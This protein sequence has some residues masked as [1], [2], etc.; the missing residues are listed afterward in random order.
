MMSE[1]SY[2]AGSASEL[3]KSIMENGFDDINR[4]L[5][6]EW[7]AKYEALTQDREH[8]PIEPDDA[9]A[10]WARTQALMFVEDEVI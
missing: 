6:A 7:I 2:M 1:A 4:Q 10:E 3:L 8:E 9:A 5:T